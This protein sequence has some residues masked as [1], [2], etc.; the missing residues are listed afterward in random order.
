MNIYKYI[1]SKDVREYNEKIGHEFNT[2]ESCFLVWRN[3]DLTLNEKHEAWRH[4]CLSVPDMEIKERLNV[5]YHPSLYVLI[6]KFVKG[7][8]CF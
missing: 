7:L 2:L 6:E 4:I 5:D 1:S 8:G 3:P